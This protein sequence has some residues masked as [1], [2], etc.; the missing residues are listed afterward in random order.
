[1][2]KHN[3]YR[4]T[5]KP[6]FATKSGYCLACKKPISVGDEIVILYFTKSKS[7]FHRDCAS[8]TGKPDNALCKGVL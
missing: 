5:G 7:P 4:N 3:Y 6:F 2:D 8:P 1:M